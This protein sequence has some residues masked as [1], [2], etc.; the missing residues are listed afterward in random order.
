MDPDHTNRYSPTAGGQI[1]SLS[2]TVS[3]RNTS[4]STVNFT[5]DFTNGFTAMKIAE[6]DTGSVSGRQAKITSTVISGSGT[7]VTSLSGFTIS[8]DWQ[9]PSSTKYGLSPAALTLPQGCFSSQTR[10]PYHRLTMEVKATGYNTKTLNKF[11]S[12]HSA[13]AISDECI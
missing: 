5:G 13:T 9:T 8:S 4:G 11:V 1:T 7:Y 6:L 10:A 12:S 3:A 2:E